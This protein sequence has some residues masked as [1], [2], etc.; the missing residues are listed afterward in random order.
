M[1]DVQNLGSHDYSYVY[2]TTLNLF[3]RRNNGYFRN[4]LSF[5]SIASIVA[6]SSLQKQ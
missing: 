4:Q 2:H 3:S 1:H 5:P 6:P